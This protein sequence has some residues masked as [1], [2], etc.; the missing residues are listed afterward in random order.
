M[1]IDKEIALPCH[2]IKIT[3]SGH[4]DSKDKNI[5][6]AGN[7]TSDLKETCEHCNDVNCHFDCSKALEYTVDKDFKI[8]LSK[9]REFMA[10]IL[11]NHSID[12]VESMILAHAMANIDIESTAYVEGIETVI[13]KLINSISF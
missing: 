9:Q 10:K 6:T 13:D 8:H 5:L 2:G 1:I 12:V 11:Y 4:T 7:I 3:I